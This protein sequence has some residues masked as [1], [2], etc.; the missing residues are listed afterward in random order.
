MKI[1][2]SIDVFSFCAGVV[3]GSVF[4]HMTSLAGDTV[5]KVFIILIATIV[6]LFVSCYLAYRYDM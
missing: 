6:F 2:F 3:L 4:W 1:N 5:N